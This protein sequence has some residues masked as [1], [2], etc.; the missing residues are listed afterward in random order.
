[1]HNIILRL[2]ANAGILLQLTGGCHSDNQAKKAVANPSPV[3][4]LLQLQRTVPLPNV[5]GGF[6]LMALD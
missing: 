3:A 2:L 6:D 1:M 4:P 5:K